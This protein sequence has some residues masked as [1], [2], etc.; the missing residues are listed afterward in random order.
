M[1]T[2]GTLLVEFYKSVKLNISVPNVEVMNPYCNEAIFHYV[3]LFSDKFYNDYHKRVLILGINPGRFGSGLTGISF[4]DPIRLQNDC[5][6]ENTL[7][8]KSELSSIFI[9]QLIKE[10]GGAHNFYKNFY[11][12]ALCP[13][14]FTQNGLNLN[15]YD[16]KDLKNLIETFIIKT[17]WQ[18][19][20]IGAIRKKCICLGQG[21][22]FKYFYNLNARH[23]FFDCII[24]LPH[25]R[26]IMQYRRKKIDE[27]VLKY[28]D[29]LKML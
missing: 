5:G 6:I 4:T 20:D 27:Y 10:F 24:P 25:P 15:Y 19:I 29:T 3:S 28:I 11:L 14:G 7:I 22:N 2:F 17:L 1:Q 23:K 26:W 12:S 16:N 18:Q 21:K 9:Y 8:K 13:L